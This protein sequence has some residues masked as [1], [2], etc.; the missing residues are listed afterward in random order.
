MAAI[1]RS[2]LQNLSPLSPR[3]KVKFTG[4]ALRNLL[5]LRA[6]T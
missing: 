3:I 1:F 6:Q 4:L 2:S 5:S